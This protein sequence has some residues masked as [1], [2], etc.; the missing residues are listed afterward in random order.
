MQQQLLSIAEIL[1]TIDATALPPDPE[2]TAAQSEVLLESRYEHLDIMRFTCTLEP[3][4]PEPHVFQL[5]HE[6]NAETALAL[7]SSAEHRTK[8]VL[9]RRLQLNEDLMPEETLQ[10]AWMK[11]LA[12]LQDRAAHLLPA[13]APSLR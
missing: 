2:R 1:Q 11:P 5:D 6:V 13:P 9:A 7:E 12:T 4:A 10:T 8:M 3:A